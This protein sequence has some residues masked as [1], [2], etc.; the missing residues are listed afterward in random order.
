VKISRPALAVIAATVAAL[1]FGAGHAEPSNS[2]DAGPLAA[3]PPVGVGVGQADEDLIVC[4]NGTAVPA[5]AKGAVTFHGDS[6]GQSGYIEVDGDSDNT[7]G[8]AC[9]DGFVRVAVDGA[10]YHFTQSP[11]GDF[12]DN[13]PSEP[14]AQ[15]SEEQEPD[16]WAQEIAA[17]CAS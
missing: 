17:N 4:N 6:E 2:C 9:M 14:S 8:P 1:S 15:R 13:D 16:V 11:D 10:G 3:G 7:G 5:P 12:D